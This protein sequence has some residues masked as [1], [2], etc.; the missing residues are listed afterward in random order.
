MGVTAGFLLPFVNK[1]GVVVLVVDLVKLL[2]GILGLVEKEEKKSC[3]VILCL[4]GQ[5]VAQLWS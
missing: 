5:L 3:T 2:V 4:R 1:L